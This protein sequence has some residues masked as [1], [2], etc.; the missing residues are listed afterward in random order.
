MRDDRLFLERLR[1]RI[2]RHERRR[3]LLRG[4]AVLLVAV[5]ALAWPHDDEPP[6]EAPV[7]LADDAVAAVDWARGDRRPRGQA[8]C[9]KDEVVSIEIT[10]ADHELKWLTDDRYLVARVR[11]FRRLIQ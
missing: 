3:F 11:D 10:D 4:A 8:V 2:D 6:A 1:R 5:A 7:A 9:F